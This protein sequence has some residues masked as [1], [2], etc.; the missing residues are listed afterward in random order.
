[1]IAGGGTAGH[2]L[3]GMAVA[4]ELVSRGIDRADIVWFGSRRGLEM[5]LVPP[6]GF[7]LVPLGGRGIQRRLTLD[8]VGAVAGLIGAIVGAIVRFGRIRPRVVLTLGGYASVAG[9][10]A[11]VVWR[12][13]LV[14]AEQ[15]ASAGAANRL[16]GRFARACAVPVEGTGLPRAVVCGNPVRAEIAAV[17]TATDRASARR[18]L[19]VPD[20]VVLIGVF[21][22]SL[23]ARRIND[24]VVG[25]AERWADRSDIFIHHVLGARDA[26]EVAPP[27]TPADGLRYRAVA[28]EEHMADLLAA[29]DVVVCRSGGTTVAELG[30]VGVAAVLVP[31][32][33]APRDHQRANAAALVDAGAAVIVSDSELTVDRLEA[34]LDP[35]VS[36]GGRAADMAQRGRAVGRRDAASAIA[37]LLEVNSR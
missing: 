1:M 2:V 35:I 21:A 19:D 24:A 26:D 5:T 28:Y 7:E 4:E 14:V 16:M 33:R 37:D 29:A 34:E 36:E 23:G 11:A 9:A 30:V 32:P 31:F 6:A 8:N 17:D 3:P 20:D 25:L 15:N 22:G 12:V 13:P 18:A 27:R 10:I